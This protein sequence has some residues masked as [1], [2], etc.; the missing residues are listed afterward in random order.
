MLTKQQT[1]IYLKDSH[2]DSDVAANDSGRVG[3]EENGAW[4]FFDIQ[5]WRFSLAFFSR[6]F[7]DFR[8]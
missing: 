2:G 6:M 7:F 8:S 3:D 4:R 5:S 1:A